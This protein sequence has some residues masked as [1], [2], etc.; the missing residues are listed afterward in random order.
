VVNVRAAFGETHRYSTFN[1][2]E[3]NCVAM[4]YHALLLG[5]N[6]RRFLDALDYPTVNLAQDDVEVFVEWSY[7]RDL[8]NTHTDADKRRS[9]ILDTLGLANDSALRA[10]PVPE[11]NAYFGASPKTSASFIQSPATW[12]V[13]RFAQTIADNDEFLRVCRFKWA[14]RVK[15]DLVIQPDADH[16]LCIEAKWESGEGTYPAT[17]T[18]VAEFA[19]R[20][21]A[22]VKQTDIQKFMMENL[23]G[24]TTTFRFLVRKPPTSPG[25]TTLTWKDAF[26]PLDLSA[27][28]AFIHRWVQSL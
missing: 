22:R 8:W 14:F 16:A 12:S 26:T 24:I 2:E 17:T 1:R 25:P 3:R 4:L 23:L 6:L 11:F 20:G 19:K 13:G 9:L 27:C 28:P 15:P 18:E 7:L 10:A 5:N 21:L